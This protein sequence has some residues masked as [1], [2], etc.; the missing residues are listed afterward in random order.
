MRKCPTCIAIHWI[1]SPGFEFAE[2]GLCFHSGVM[3]PAVDLLTAD[4]Y[5]LQFGTNVLGHFYLTELLMPTLRAGAKTAPGGRARVITTSSSGAYLGALDY[6]TFKDTPERKK[7][8]KE[9]LY[10]QSKLVCSSLSS[11]ALRGALRPSVPELMSV[12]CGRAAQANCVV[13]RQ[14]AQRYGDEGILSISVNPG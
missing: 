4:G 8:S 5:D 12:L 2:L 13:A 7:M 9:C 3:W 10:Y 11:F 6:S 1:C 14:V